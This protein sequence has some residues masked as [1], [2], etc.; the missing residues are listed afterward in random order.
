[1]RR[2]TFS[3]VVGAL[4]WL[5]GCG[6]RLRAR[7]EIPLQYRPVSIEAPAGSAVAP[8][9]RARLLTTGV[10]ISEDPAAARLRLHLSG[11]RRAARVA[12]V[13]LNG[14]TLAWELHDLIDFEALGPDGKVLLPR[15]TLDISRIF[16]NPDIEVL[17]KQLE[18]AQIYEDLAAELADRILMRLRA[19]LP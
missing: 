1:M 5:S 7:A 16:D 2:R 12:A 18:Q 10:T 19:A 4:A 15:Q 17:G 8:I 14:K 3:G 13:D 6:F 11:E 9:I